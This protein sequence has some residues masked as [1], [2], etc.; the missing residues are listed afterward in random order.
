LG[1]NEFLSLIDYV[2]KIFSPNDSVISNYATIVKI[3]TFLDAGI[4]GSSK[5]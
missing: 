2:G 4:P 3:A 5:D 1:H